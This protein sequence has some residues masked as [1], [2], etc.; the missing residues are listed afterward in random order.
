MSSFNIGGIKVTIKPETTV[1]VDY[2]KLT[3]GSM[4]NLVRMVERETVRN[5]DKIGKIL[6]EALKRGLIETTATELDV[7][8]TPEPT[9]EL[10][11]AGS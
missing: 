8:A 6:K 10:A 9:P 1:E 5:P 3:D 2:S 11:E 7:E 4:L